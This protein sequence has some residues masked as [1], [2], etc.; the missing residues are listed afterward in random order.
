MTT[1]IDQFVERTATVLRNTGRGKDAEALVTALR[2]PAGG[3]PVVHVV[4]EDKRGKSTL[5]NALLGTPEA[6]PTGVEV[7][8]SAPI[9]FFATKEPRALVYRYGQPEAEQ[10]DVLTGRTLATLAGN[11]GNIQNVRSVQIGLDVELLRQLVIVDTPGVGGLES[12][13]GAMTLQSLRRADAL[14]FVL[15]AGAQ[16][17]AA[18]LEFLREAS[19]KVDTVVIALTKIDVNRGWR[20]IMADNARILAEQAP[21]FAG[22]PIIPVSGAL[23]LR[24][25]SEPDEEDRE[26]LTEESGVPKLRSLLRSQV[27]GRIEVLRRTNLV[28]TTLSELLRSERTLTDQLPRGDDAELQRQLQQEK[29]RLAR[30]KED[31]ADWPNQLDLHLRRLTLERGETA[32]TQMA[33]IRH[34]YDAKLRKL[35]KKDFDSLP[36]ELIADLTALDAQLN[37]AAAADIRAFLADLLQGL[38]AGSS[39][40]DSMDSLTDSSLQTQLSAMTLGKHK[41]NATDKISIMSMFSRG[42]SLS[43]LLSGSGLGLTAATFLA[44]PVGLLLGLG[45][46][47]ALAVQGFRCRNESA[48]G[49]EFRSWMQEQMAQ[50]QTTITN[51]FQRATIDLQ[52]GV[53][54][55]IREALSQREAEINDSM[56][57]LQRLMKAQTTERAKLVEDTE[58]RLTNVRALKNDAARLFLELSSPVA[59]AA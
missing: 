59:A 31:R 10:T 27:A 21:R 58:R 37:E 32:S 53:K 38:D 46:G 2:K 3:K 16:F 14:V 8:T 48:Y 50:A 43:S 22:A 35:A 17:R 52:S 49:V 9:T 36:G 42:T 40:A 15:E 41:L 6:S 23:A 57:A 4:G 34:R 26:A 33:V 56:E 13:H 1:D 39:L 18:E 28:R 45:V 51:G 7:T 20:T 25:L 24:A 12:G 30:L 55:M 47:A 44:P 5:V 29:Q 19:E 54:K 11:P